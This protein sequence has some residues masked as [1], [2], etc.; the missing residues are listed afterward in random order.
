VNHDRLVRL[1]V[2]ADVFQI[3]P[4][5]ARQVVID[6]HGAQLPI[7]AQA[8]ADDEIDFRAVER[9]FAALDRQVG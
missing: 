6:L 9:R 5:L 8:I 7:A 3:E 2:G 1:I 4:L